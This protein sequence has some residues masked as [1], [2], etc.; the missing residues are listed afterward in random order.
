[1]H[2]SDICLPDESFIKTAPTS[3]IF[4]KLQVPP[5]LGYVPLALE[6]T[7]RFHTAVA[8]G[9][10]ESFTL[11]GRPRMPYVCLLSD[12]KEVEVTITARVYEPRIVAL[13][14][15]IKSDLEMSLREL[16]DVPGYIG[17]RGHSEIDALVQRVLRIIACQKPT[18]DASPSL[19]YDQYPLITISDITAEHFPTW[20]ELAK[21]D[22]ARILIRNVAD[23]LMRDELVESLFVKSEQFNY[24]T[25]QE[26]LLVDKQGAVSVSALSVDTASAEAR[27]KTIKSAMY[28]VELGLVFR[29]FLD[30][31]FQLRMTNQIVADYVYSR[32]EPWCFNSSAVLRRSVTGTHLWNLISHELKVQETFSLIS[33]REYVQ[34]AVAS[35]LEEFDRVANSDRHWLT[36]LEQNVRYPGDHIDG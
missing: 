11:R 16:A 22:I 1:M 10:P 19:Q 35:Q 27:K 6:F 5:G 9:L 17:I 3:K 26:Y 25:N 34:T 14:V 13:Q 31:Y 2:D 29:H 33:S 32:I 36:A 18:T 30:G 12:G 23:G 8:K 21:Q 24:K 4:S 15:A 28:L 7:S 20:Q